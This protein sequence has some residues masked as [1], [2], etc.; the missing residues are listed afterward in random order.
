MMSG[1]ERPALH[2]KA[3]VGQVDLTYVLH[4]C[5]QVLAS[6]VQSELSLKNGAA[7]GSITS[8]LQPSTAFKVNR[9]PKQTVF[10]QKSKRS[11]S[12]GVIS[13]GQLHGIAS[14][15]I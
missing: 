4:D 10:S 11:C 1:D 3:A 7:D 8:K 12:S 13:G 14:A 15:H 5:V 2:A 6:G 9:L